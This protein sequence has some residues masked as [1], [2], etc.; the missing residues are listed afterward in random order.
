MQLIIEYPESLPDALQETPAELEKEMR[1]ALA[2]KLFEMKRIPSGIAATL[3]GTD[4]VSFLMGLS[5]YGVPAI[6]LTKEELEGD[7]A[8][9]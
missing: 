3:A 8:N 2:V 4:R 1:A 9:V 5:R 7:I 6:D